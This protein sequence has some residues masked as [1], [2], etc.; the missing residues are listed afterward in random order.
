VKDETLEVMDM[1]PQ[2]L[3]ARSASQKPPGPR[4][5]SRS[6]PDIAEAALDASGIGIWEYDIA[7]GVV[8]WSDSTFR[9][10][11]LVADGSP[12]S[13]GSF[14]SHVHPEDHELAASHVT[15]S[16]GQRDVYVSEFRI[17]RSDG[18]TRTILCRGRAVVDEDDT[19]VG[20]VGALVDITEQRETEKLRD[21]LVDVVSHDLKNPLGAIL[22]GIYLILKMEPPEAI[23]QIATRI[24]TSA[25]RM[26][27]IVESLLDASRVRREHLVPILPRPTDLGEVAARVVDEM[28]MAHP[29]RSLHLVVEGDAHVTCDEDRVE[30]VLSN[31]MLNGL[32]HG[33][34]EG[35]VEVRLLRERVD[36]GLVIE[37]HNRG[38]AIP[39]ETAARMFTAFGRGAGAGPGLGLGLFIARE[40]VAA[41]GGTLDFTSS[42]KVGT[43]FRVRLPA[44]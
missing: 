34:P 4:L 41:H 7:S 17:C 16:L 32:V 14:L 42:Q 12:Q 18:A 36:G 38:D 3:D 39:E 37:V 9:I 25:N 35:P 23:S 27:N 11:G 6:L 19:A 29:S 24:R 10:F 2:H 26:R 44:A 20:L 8:T 22:G 43:T 1:Q 40:I 31:L 33:E 30:Q 5:G 13:Y 21:A 15:H 28:R